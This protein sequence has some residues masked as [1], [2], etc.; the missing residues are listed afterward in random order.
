MRRLA[1]GLAL[2]AGLLPAT[3]HAASAFVTGYVERGYTASGTWTHPGTAACPPW[4]PF[5]TAVWLSGIGV[6]TC[7]DS[8]SLRLSPRFDCWVPT[9]D[10]AY[11]LTGWHEYEVLP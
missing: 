7:E 8:Y 3:A 5:Q 4:L 11:A 9:V 1:A 6:V 10:E 2:L